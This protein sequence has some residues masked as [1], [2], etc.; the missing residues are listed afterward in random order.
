MRTLGS[1]P[2]T[3]LFIGGIHGDEAEGAAATA[4]LPDAFTAAGLGDRVT[5]YVV[6]DANPDGRA[7]GTRDNANGVDVNRNFPAT[8]FAP[9]N[10]ASGGE[11]AN[12]PETRAI[13]ETIDRI[14]PQMVIVLHSWVGQEFVNF[15]GPARPIAERFS[16]TSGL[17]VKASGE[18]A[19]TPGSLG[20]YAGRDRG[21][22]VLTIE[23]LKG[24]NPGSDWLKI[25]DALL[26]SIAG[27]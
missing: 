11:P 2:R 22:A 8:N 18:F 24:S 9:G 19:A 1:G 5:L 12:Q 20:S 3:V 25:R 4:A 6:E 13:V 21:V 16:A 14:R 15:D 7:A 10:S 27:D 26:Q 17:P 23:L